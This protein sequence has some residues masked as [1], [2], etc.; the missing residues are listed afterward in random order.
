MPIPDDDQRLDYD[1]RASRPRDIFAA[2]PKPGPFDQRR[3]R[4]RLAIIVAA[5][6]LVAIS[7][8]AYIVLWLNDARQK[9]HSNSSLKQIGLAIHN[10][11][12]VNGDLPHNTYDRDGKPLL[13][14]RV[15]ILPF[16]VEDPLY[17]QFKLDEPWDSPNN[18]R[19]L[20]QMP[21]IYTRPADRGTGRET[22]TYYRG[23]SNPGAVF[24]RRAG[25]VWPPNPAIRTGLLQL[26][27][28][29]DGSSNT[30]LVVE[31]GDP[32]EWTKPDDLDASPG[33]PFPKMGGM[34]WRNGKFQA[35][36]C[37]GSTRSFPV[38]IDEEKLRALISHSGGEE[39]PE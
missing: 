37:D 16:I 20:N 14:W 26:S 10:Y 5:A 39:V 12:D 23:F 11:H 7:A 22:R 24:E 9:V 6:A 17:K 18:I 38:D 25:E 32:V 13:S 27:D 35:L 36:M 4:V 34:R 31:S 33:L 28:L 1:E 21:V 3:K 19:L 8:I 29:K 15:H 2:T 30:I